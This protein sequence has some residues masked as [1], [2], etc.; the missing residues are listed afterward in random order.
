MERVKTGIEGLDKMLKG[1]IP[2]K[3][4]IALYGGPGSGKTSLS[5]EFILNGARNNEAGLY[6]TLEETE[7]DIIENIKN[8]FSDLSK[9]IDK[10]IKEDKIKIVKP[11]DMKIETIMNIIEQDMENRDTKRIVIDSST[12]IRLSFSDVLEYR[13]TL[14]EFF[15]L[16]RNLECNVIMTVEADSARREELKFKIE[17]YVLDGIIN[18][19]NLDRGDKRVRALEIFKMRGT[20]HSRA[21]VPFKVTPKGV[22]VYSEE[23]VF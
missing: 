16:L 22:K 7:D 6:I 18:L 10:L 8:T 3:R 23:K 11:E 12:M 5:F 4:H 15:D 17:H 1:G 19:Y 2:Y 21:L 9:E 13:R 20:D 14:F